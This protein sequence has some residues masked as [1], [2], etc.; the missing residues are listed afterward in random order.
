MYFLFCIVI[1]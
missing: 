1:T